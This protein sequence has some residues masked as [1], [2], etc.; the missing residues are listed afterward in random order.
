[1]GD[2]GSLAL[3]GTIA[4]IACLTNSVLILPFLTAV[5][6]GETLSVIIQLTSKRFFGRKVFHIAPVHHHYEH[7]G[8]PEYKVTMRFWLIGAFFCTFGV[9]L[10]LGGIIQ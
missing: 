7:L 6:I 5:F 10:Y 2:T 1:M 3:G 8:W 4:V 9:I